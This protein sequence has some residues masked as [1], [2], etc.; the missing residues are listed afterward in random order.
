M[1]DTEASVDT[2][3]CEP[4][5]R[6]FDIQLQHQQ[7]IFFLYVCIY[8]INWSVAFNRMFNLTKPIKQFW[9]YVLSYTET[10]MDTGTCESESEYFTGDTSIDIHM[11]TSIPG[12]WDNA[13]TSATDNF[14][15]MF[16]FIL[17]IGA[18]HLTGYLIYQNQLSTFDIM[19]S[20]TQRPQWVPGHLNPD[21]G[22]L[23]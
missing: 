6:D 10:S 13:T 14:F 1:S 2:G 11:W 7:D 8:F 21:T 23:T 16:V 19:L 4:R 22:T 5:Y 15:Y 17:Q 3:T 20:Q 9:Y 18:L 12:L